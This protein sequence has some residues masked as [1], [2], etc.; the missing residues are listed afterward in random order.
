MVCLRKVQC[1]HRGMPSPSICQ[2]PEARLTQLL[3]PGKR[4]ILGLTGA[5]G[6]GKSTLAARLA[7]RYDAATVAVVPMDGF[8]LA[9]VQLTRLGLSHT[10]GAANTF[11]VAGYV[12]LLRRLRYPVAG[13]TIYAPDFRREIEEPIAGAIAVSATVPLVITEGNYLLSDGPWSAVQPLLDEVWYVDTE[14]ELRRQRLVARHVAHGRT[15]AQAQ[16][17]A[18]TTDKPNAELV[19]AGRRRADRIVM[20]D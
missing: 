2:E 6:A 12:A 8:H 17:W 14:E 20:N 3:A 15:P 1:L 16:A 9:N 18:A 5:P 10:K 13:E 19:R 11:D 4:R 7:S